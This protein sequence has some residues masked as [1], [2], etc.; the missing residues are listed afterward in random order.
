[1]SEEVS[2]TYADL[3]RW[4][5]ADCG[6]CEPYDGEGDVPFCFEA[7]EQEIEDEGR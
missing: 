5:G 7:H 1:M 2:G 6:R 3:C 4:Y